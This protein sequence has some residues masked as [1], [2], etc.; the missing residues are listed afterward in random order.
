[1]HMVEVLLFVDQLIKVFVSLG[2]NSKVSGLSRVVYSNAITRS[3][4][5]IFKNG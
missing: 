5:I 3:K 2:C 4:S 1:M